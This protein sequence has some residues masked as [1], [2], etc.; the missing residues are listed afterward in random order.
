MNRFTEE[1]MNRFQENAAVIAQKVDEQHDAVSIMAEL[2]AD[3]FGEKSAQ[4]GAVIAQDIL[5]NVRMFDINYKEAA[6]DI[7]GFIRKFQHRTEKGM[8]DYQKCVYWH[9]FAAA[10]AAATV[11][12][13]S[14][15]A[16]AQELLKKAESSKPDKQ[17]CNAV[18]VNRFRDLAFEALKNSTVFT[19]TLALHSDEMAEISDANTAAKLLIQLGEDSVAFRA[20]TS[21]LVYIAVAK[22]EFEEIP[23]DFSAAQVAVAVCTQTEQ[24]NIINHLKANDISVGLASDLLKFLGILVITSFVSTV[25]V[26]GGF[27]IMDIYHIL[28]AIPL[29]I[30]L[31]AVCLVAMFKGIEKWEVGSQKLAY[32]IVSGVRGLD[33]FVRKVYLYA[34]ENI[35]PSAVNH[36][37]AIGK[38]ISD[39]LT[40]AV[41][42]DELTQAETEELADG[43]PV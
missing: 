29:I 6:Q 16:V 38:K 35:V 15:D 28:V 39:S 1:Q 5:S 31:V 8:T 10:V 12:A 27:F 13:D 23:V 20:I 24:V 14:D 43:N 2:Y 19:Q 4:E 25:G 9:D 33:D 18:F 3:E 21:M 40:A 34:S 11:A 17:H 26:V 7:N 37:K 42:A 36:A 30:A 41:D 32:T 22:G